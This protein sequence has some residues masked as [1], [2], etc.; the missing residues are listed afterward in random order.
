MAKSLAVES[1]EKFSIENLMAFKRDKILNIRF[2][3]FYFRRISLLIISQHDIQNF[4]LSFDCFLTFNIPEITVWLLCH[5]LRQQSIAFDLTDSFTWEDLQTRD[6]DTGHLTAAGWIPLT[7]KY[8][9]SVAIGFLCYHSVQTTIRIVT[10][11]ET[12]FTVW[13]PFDWT[14]SPFYEL[15]NILQVNF[16]RQNPTLSILTVFLI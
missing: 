6:V 8:S 5:R 14:F 2:S 3:E 9:R 13:Y 16:C 1:T 15:V 10:N 11:H 12:M 7:M 4:L